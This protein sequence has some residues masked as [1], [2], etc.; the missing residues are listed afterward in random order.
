VV[1]HI[2][3]LLENQ[4][5]NILWIVCSKLCITESKVEGRG[6]TTFANSCLPIIIS[7]VTSNNPPIKLSDAILSNIQ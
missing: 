6:I 2:Y 7:P 1:A 3:R 5:Y 4:W